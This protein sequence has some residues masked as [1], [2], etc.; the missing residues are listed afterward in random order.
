MANVQSPTV[1]K[2]VGQPLEECGSQRV[3]RLLVSARPTLILTYVRHLAD[4]DC[5]RN[6][7]FLTHKDVRMSRML[8]EQFGPLAA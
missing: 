3:R 8:A 5:F 1:T 4:V 2:C 7:F 6:V